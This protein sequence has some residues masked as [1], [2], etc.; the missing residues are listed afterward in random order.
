MRSPRSQRAGLLTG[1]YRHQ[2]WVGHMVDDP[3]LFPGYTDDLNQNCATI[4]EV[5]EGSG[6]QMPMFGK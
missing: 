3:K 6:Y 5:L 4:A 1:C 2:T